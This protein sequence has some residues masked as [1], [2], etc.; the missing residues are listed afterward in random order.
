MMLPTL[1]AMA[2]TNGATWMARRSA[3]DGTVS[4]WSSPPTVPPSPTQCLAVARMVS[5]GAQ[6]GA[7]EPVDVG[8]HHR[9]D[10]RVLPEALVSAAPPLVA[11]DAQT[12]REGPGDPGGVGL[13]GRDLADLLRER[14]VAGGAQPDVVGENR[15]AVDVAV[16]V[17][18]VDAEDDRDAE[19]ARQ[20]RRL[21]AVDHVGPVGGRVAAGGGAAAAGQQRAQSIRG[22]VG[23]GGERV[24]AGL[25][26]LAEQE[27]AARGVPGRHDR[28]KGCVAGH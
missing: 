7:L 25:G 5:G 18:G 27:D 9:G 15:G 23:V 2:S 16:A 3:S 1:R 26:Q 13:L 11:G 19:P 24:V 8:G 6:V 22:D 14:R 21:I 20:R 17:H 4:P 12:R 10:L 28:G